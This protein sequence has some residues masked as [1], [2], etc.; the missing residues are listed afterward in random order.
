[1]DS[2]E[3]CIYIE[4]LRS[5]RKISQENLTDGLVSIR[6]YRRYLNGVSDMPFDIF[7]KMVE[8]MGLRTNT[9]LKEMENSRDEEYRYCSKLYNYAITYNY[10][11]FNKLLNNNPYTHF[12][13]SNNQLL[14]DL[15]CVMKD[16]Y[17][18]KGSKKQAF[19]E[20]GDLINYPKI[21]SHE[22]IT[23]IELLALSVLVDLG[24]KSA[25]QKIIERIF[26]FYQNEKGII[27]GWNNR[28]QLLIIAKFAQIFGIEEDYQM[29]IDFCD[30]GI[31]KN[32]STKSYYLSE[33]YY[34]Y[35][36]LAYYKLEMMA[37]FEDSLR[38]CFNV[39][40][41]DNTLNMKHFQYLI[42]DDYGFEFREHVIKLYNEEINKKSE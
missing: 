11:S 8:K 27:G 42:K 6:Q 37:E 14:F 29:V 21:L 38:K 34:Y 36:S 9:I 12:I 15:A 39:L 1:M 40:E 16:Y 28:Y 13:D 24:S 22:M 4:R 20:I 3:L 31:K 32:N 5:S 26:Y 10:V 7:I 33:F 2:R 18:N 25:R 35:K 17:Q 41:M 30:I 19:E 23:E